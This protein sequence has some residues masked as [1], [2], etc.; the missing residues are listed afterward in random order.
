MTRDRWGRSALLAAGMAAFLLAAAPFLEAQPAAGRMPHHGPF[1]H[2]VKCFRILDLTESQKGA[3][4]A[5][6]E[7]AKPEA[8]ALHAVF[9]ADRAA[10]KAAFETNPP[11]PCA[12]GAAEL[13]LKADREV[14]RALFEKVR[15]GVLAILT[16]AQ[17]AKLAGCLEAPRDVPPA[18]DA[19]DPEE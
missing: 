10:L 7:A 12:I 9:E 8:E 17:Q 2:I 13:K 15:N 1:G 19:T 14:R 11:D 5:V 6:L 18:G 4:R 16:P 3:I